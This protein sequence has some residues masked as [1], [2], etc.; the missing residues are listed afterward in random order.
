MQDIV[1]QEFELRFILNLNGYLSLSLIEQNEP[2][3]KDFFIN[4]E[5]IEDNSL[6]E[7]NGLYISSALSIENVSNSDIEIL[8]TDPSVNIELVLSMLSRQ[9]LREL[10]YRVVDGFELRKYT[11]VLLQNILDVNIGSFPEF[12]LEDLVK[13]SSVMGEEV[14]IKVIK[15]FLTLGRFEKAKMCYYIY[16]GGQCLENDTDYGRIFV[17]NAIERLENNVTLTIKHQYDRFL[18]SEINLDDNEAPDLMMSLVH[19]LFLEGRFNECVEVLKILMVICQKKK[20]WLCLYYGYFLEILCF[21]FMNQFDSAYGR[22]KVYSIFQYTTKNMQH[23]LDVGIVISSI[24]CCSMGKVD[25][26]IVNR[27]INKDLNDS[28]NVFYQV[29]TS[30]CKML[31]EVTSIDFSLSRFLKIERELESFYRINQVKESWNIPDFTTIY[32]L[33]KIRNHRVKMPK[34]F[35]ESFVSCFYQQKIRD[36][37]YKSVSEFNF[38]VFFRSVRKQMQS[39]LNSLRTGTTYEYASLTNKEQHVVAFLKHGYSYTEIANALGIS[40]NTVKTHTNNIYKKLKI[41]GKNDLVS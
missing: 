5:F 27:V 38:P 25:K 33:A 4:S 8:L 21:G 24:W 2:K 19:E 39:N 12:M 7:S 6:M 16:F 10:Y 40:P 14:L 41:S 17:H 3:I 30:Y 20:R 11:S 13:R 26:R 31:V 37:L 9:G 36:F 35:K 22:Y 15:I 18:A 32:E 1:D 23:M 28:Y 34:V 29:Y